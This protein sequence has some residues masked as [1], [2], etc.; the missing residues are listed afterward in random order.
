MIK[1]LPSVFLQPESQQSKIGSRQTH[2]PGGQ[3][4]QTTFLSSARMERQEGSSRFLSAEPVSEEDMPWWLSV[5]LPV[6]IFNTGWQAAR[7]TEE[8]ASY[9]HWYP[10]ERKKKIVATNLSDCQCEHISAQVSDKHAVTALRKHLN[11]CPTCP[12]TKSIFHYS[13]ASNAKICIIYLY[14]MDSAIALKIWFYI[15]CCLVYLYYVV[16]NNVQTQRKAWFI[17]G[18]VTFDFRCLYQL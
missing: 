12:G 10:E 2:D 8:I 9:C 3:R 15:F 1:T 7:D 16:S 4:W 18:N 13:T 14:N 5:T 11:I 6:T 17:Y